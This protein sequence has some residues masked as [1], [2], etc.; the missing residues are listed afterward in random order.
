MFDSDIMKLFE[1]FF[2]PP[3]VTTINSSLAC[4]NGFQT[5]GPL[6]DV[7]YEQQ[8]RRSL[9]ALDGNQEVFQW[10]LLIDW[11]IG[12]HIGTQLHVS[13]WLFQNHHLKEVSRHGYMVLSQNLILHIHFPIRF[14]SAGA[15]REKIGSINL[16]KYQ[17]IK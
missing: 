13:S 11:H 12:H 8:S 9:D 16:L 2:H 14:L 7:W 1:V 17:L 3:S 10:N 4:S 15:G 5:A 6:H